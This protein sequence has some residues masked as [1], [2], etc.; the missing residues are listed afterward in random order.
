MRF[1]KEKEEYIGGETVNAYESLQ[2]GVIAQALYPNTD[3][4]EA[5]NLLIWGQPRLHIEALS[6]KPNQANKQT[7]KPIILMISD[8]TNCI[9]VAVWLTTWRN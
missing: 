1:K 7:N 9:N 3:Q 6:E 2:S 4:A 8:S 5:G